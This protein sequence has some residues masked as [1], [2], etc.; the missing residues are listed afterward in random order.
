MNSVVL[1]GRL[2]KDP[3]V[4]YSQD[5]NCIATFTLAINRPNKNGESKADFLRVISFGKT[6]ELVERFLSRGRQVAVNGRIQTDK[7]TNKDNVVVYTTDI[8]AERVEFLGSK[9]DS[10]DVS[11][12]TEGNSSPL[13]EGFSAMDDDI[14]F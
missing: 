6:A 10:H 14:P 1:I 5:N 11:D 3:E 2:T 7:Y 9:N 8:I 13:A 4:R 12:I